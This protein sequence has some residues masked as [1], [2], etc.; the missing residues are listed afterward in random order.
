ML[1][2]S[3]ARALRAVNM[4]LEVACSTVPCVLRADRPIA[5]NV[6]VILAASLPLRGVSPVVS[7]FTFRLSCSLS[8]VA[9]VDFYSLLVSPRSSRLYGVHVSEAFRHFPCFPT[10]YP[11][12]SFVRYIIQEYPVGEAFPWPGGLL[13]RSK[14]IPNK[15]GSE[16]KLKSSTT[17]WIWM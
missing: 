6:R 9:C 17:K 8:P 14:P 4:M 12:K 10:R 15:C 1:E 11:A 16:H 5:I 3:R 7:L 2:E 13:V